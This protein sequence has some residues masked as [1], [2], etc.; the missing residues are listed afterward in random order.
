MLWCNSDSARCGFIKYASLLCLT[1]WKSPVTF[2]ANLS[3]ERDC[4]NLSARRRPISLPNNIRA[5]APSDSL[6]RNADDRDEWLR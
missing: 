5:Q 6:P 1:V 3:T 4:I 2:V